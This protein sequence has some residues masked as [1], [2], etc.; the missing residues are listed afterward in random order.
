[1][2][3][4]PPAPKPLDKKEMF[5]YFKCGICDKDPQK[6]SQDKE[7]GRQNKSRLVHTKEMVKKWNGIQSKL[8]EKIKD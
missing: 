6:K 2:P 3:M 1:M 8:S 4:K 7:E 5:D